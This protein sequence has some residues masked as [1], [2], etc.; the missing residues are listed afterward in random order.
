MA[1]ATPRKPQRTPQDELDGEEV[2][3]ITLYVLFVPIP[4][5]LSVD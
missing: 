5:S 3:E 4:H 1:F 2:L